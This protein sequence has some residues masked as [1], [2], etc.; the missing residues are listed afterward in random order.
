MTSIIKVDTFQNPSG[1]N[2]INE[3][4]GTVTIAK[5]GNTVNVASGATLNCDSLTI[6]GTAY[7]PFLV[8]TVTGV[9]PAS[10]GNTQTS[11]IITGTNFI[12]IPV[13]DAIHSSTGAIVPA[14]TVTFNSS[15]SVTCNFT[16]TTNGTYYIR[17]ENNSG[18][19][20]R[21]STA[22]LTVA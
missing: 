2:L 8:P 11:V 3:N 20:G 12:S 16:L 22:L 10:I 7:D 5:I 6:G 4:A 18:I 19:A 21:S 9:S 17:V 14:D 1:D 15:I 13:V